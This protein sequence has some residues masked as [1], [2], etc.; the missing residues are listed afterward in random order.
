MPALLSRPIDPSSPIPLPLAPI[1]CC[2]GPLFWSFAHAA[3]VAMAFLWLKFSQ[4]FQV[5][6]ILASTQAHCPTPSPS[7]SASGPARASRPPWALPM[8]HSP[9]RWR[10]GLQPIVP[11]QR[12]VDAI[13]GSRRRRI[14]WH[15]GVARVGVSP[16]P[17]LAP[18]WGLLSPPR[19]PGVKASPNGAAIAAD[20]AESFA[21]PSSC[22]HAAR[23]TLLPRLLHL[24]TLWTVRR[25][26]TKVN[27]EAYAG[28]QDKFFSHFTISECLPRFWSLLAPIASSLF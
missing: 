14:R 11:R 2:Q 26:C 5:L 17:C 1:P 27:M 6:A 28:L 20:R 18:L 4:S 9:A 23:G 15:Q 10:G 25:T 19:E 12:C 13:R 24:L 22:R 16:F 21:T 8:S 7:G 3:S